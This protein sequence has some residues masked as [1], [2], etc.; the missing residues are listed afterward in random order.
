MFDAVMGWAMDILHFSW[1]VILWGKKHLKML[2]C[3]NIVESM[4]SGQSEGDNSC[5]RTDS[6]FKMWK[7]SDISGTDSIPISTELPLNVWKLSHLDVSFCP[8]THNWILSPRKHQDWR[9]EC[10]FKCIRQYKYSGTS[11]YRFSRGWRKQTMNAGKR[12]I[13]ETITHCK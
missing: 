7:F 8:R 13:R 1:L 9:R 4:V 10:W 6:C 5:S 2:K 12:L 11:I 3:R